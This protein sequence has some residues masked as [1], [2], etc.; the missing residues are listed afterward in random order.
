[1]VNV[2]I[3][4]SRK[5][6]K[7]SKQ[8]HYYFFEILEGFLNAYKWKVKSGASV[9]LIANFLMLQSAPFLVRP[10]ITMLYVNRKIIT[11]GNF[12]TCP[13]TPFYVN[14]SLYSHFSKPQIHAWSKPQQ[15]HILSVQLMCQ[16][17]L[18]ARR[19]VGIQQ[20]PN[21][22]FMSGNAKDV[23]SIIINLTE[24]LHII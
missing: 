10:I 14:I 13:L 11:F 3:E 4:E 5:K 20:K 1:M 17:D 24:A 6:I 21:N 18:S 8:I 16:N 19:K 22:V 23:A 12:V 7:Y 2:N 15:I 9:N